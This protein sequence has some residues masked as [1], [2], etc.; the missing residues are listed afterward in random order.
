M[1]TYQVQPLYHYS[2]TGNTEYISKEIARRLDD[3]CVDLLDRIKN[4]DFT[5]FHSEKPFIICAPVYVCEMPRFMS[6]YL[7]KQTF[8]G[9]K[10]VGKL[11]MQ[12]ASENLIPV[13]LEL[14]G[15]SPCIV[16]KSSKIPLAAKRIV[17]GKFI[18]SGQTCVAPDYILCDASIKEK[19]IDV[20]PHIE[21]FIEE[22]ASAFSDLILNHRFLKVMRLHMRFTFY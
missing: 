20:F 11:V 3:E 19:L 9:S 8:T 16:E 14:G 1:L 21:N 10:D 4:Q 15:K 5:E 2:A 18:N 12:K 6:A 22:N 17:F 7:K 13:T